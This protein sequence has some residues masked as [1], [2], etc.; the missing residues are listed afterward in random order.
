[1]SAPVLAREML[2]K[3]NTC[4]LGQDYTNRRLYDRSI[5]NDDAFEEE[6]RLEKVILLYR[7]AG[8]WD[9]VPWQEAVLVNTFDGQ[10]ADFSLLGIEDE[11]GYAHLLWDVSS[12]EDSTYNV[13]IQSQ[14]VQLQ[15]SAARGDLNFVNTESVEVVLDRSPPEIYGVPQ[16]ELQGSV[17]SVER[18]EFIFS[19]TEALFC[20]EPY[21]FSVQI[22]LSAEGDSRVFSN[23]SG[24]STI[25]LGREIR[26][27][28]SMNTLDYLQEMASEVDFRIDLLNVEDLARNQM[29]TLQFNG[30][31]FLVSED[32]C[33]VC[34]ATGYLSHSLFRQP[35][36]Q[37]RVRQ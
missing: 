30:T 36:H 16:I 15:S 12:V 5:A 2:C 11:F 24:I 17:K 27:R 14:C 6:K 21:I 33:G 34:T 35:L 32:K 22:T 31:W 20:M 29:E 19:F 4:F 37:A 10:T 23:D 25:C 26:Y 3:L 9:P 7:R 18:Q 13:K 1:M 28:F 8:D